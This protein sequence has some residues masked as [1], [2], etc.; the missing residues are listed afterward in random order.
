MN[1][2]S[3]TER[4][5]EFRRLCRQRGERCTVQRRAV[6]E[7]VLGLDNHPSVDQVYEAVRPRLPGVARPTV[8]RTLDHLAR[9]GVINRA[10]HPGHVAR[11]DSRTDPHHHL[12]CLRCH[13]VVDFQD[14]GLDG[15]QIPDT[16]GLGFDVLDYG[17][18]LRGICR[19]C[20]AAEGKEVF[21]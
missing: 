4:V 19:D 13:A 15:L 8:Y 5:Q 9:M 6:L 1:H 21:R 14:D 17:V 18:Q 7:A 12:V 3:R 10:C 20:R 16:S 2:A 11:F